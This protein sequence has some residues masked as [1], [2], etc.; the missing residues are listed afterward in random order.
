MDASI[1]KKINYS[2]YI[3]KQLYDW[4]L[5]LDMSKEQ[6]IEKLDKITVLKMIFFIAGVSSNKY[7]RNQ[8]LLK[9]FDKFLAMPYGPVEVDVFNSFAEISKYIENIPNSNDDAKSTAEVVEY[10]PT[11][12]NAINRIKQLNYELVS[13]DS[14]TLVWISHK[15]DCW[16]NTYG[17]NNRK[18]NLISIDDIMNSGKYLG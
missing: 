11:I 10:K 7:D 18:N 15:W 9:V 1:E 4:C 16:K 12:D 17:K 6:A 14:F 13:L 3:V 2:L 5:E 8:G